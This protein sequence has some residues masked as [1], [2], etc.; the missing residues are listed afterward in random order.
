VARFVT[1]WKPST[2]ASYKCPAGQRR[3]PSSDTCTSDSDCKDK[4]CEFDS[5]QGC[6]SVTCPVGSTKV[7]GTVPCASK[8]ECAQVCCQRTCSTFYDRFACPAP[9]RKK[10]GQEHHHCTDDKECVLECCE[11][12][13]CGMH[14]AMFPCKDPPVFPHPAPDTTKCNGEVDCRSRCCPLKF[15][16]PPIHDGPTISNPPKP[17][18]CERNIPCLGLCLQ[19][20]CGPGLISLMPTK[21]KG[22]CRDMCAHQCGGGK[23]VRACTNDAITFKIRGRESCDTF[24]R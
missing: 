18:D 7:Q 23:S 5:S 8:E 13:T 14:R 10:A 1:S 6:G 20:K 4:C 21:G 3:K 22:V 15:V 2:C 9:L 16:P 12:T 24:C 17:R 11:P 19:N